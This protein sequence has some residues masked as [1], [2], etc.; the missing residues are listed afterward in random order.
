MYIRQAYESGQKYTACSIQDHRVKVENC[1][2]PAKGTQ[3]SPA[4]VQNSRCRKPTSDQ[5]SVPT[6]SPRAS[7]PSF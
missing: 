7:T 2:A 1:T 4:S 3:R 6:T 5:H